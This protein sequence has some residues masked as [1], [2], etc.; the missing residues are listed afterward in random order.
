MMDEREHIHQKWV[1]SRSERIKLKYK[2][3][4]RMKDEEIKR[5]ARSD[6]NR[7]YEEIAERAEEAA[8]K[9]EMSRVY[10]IT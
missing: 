3:E 6:K 4:H 8:R 5:K 10:E 2:E 1:S 7:Y 9:G